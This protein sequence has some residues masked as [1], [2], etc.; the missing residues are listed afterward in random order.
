MADRGAHPLDLVLAALVERELDGDGPS[1]RTCAGAVGPSSSSTPFA[2]RSQRLVG[3]LALD[4]GDVDL[5]DLVARMRE[6]VRERR[7]RS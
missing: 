4:L 7:R 3:R 6:P 1:R 2:S 5:L